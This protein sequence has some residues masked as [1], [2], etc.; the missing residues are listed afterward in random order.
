MVSTSKYIIMFALK[1]WES[2]TS[3][4]STQYVE[5]IC[6]WSTTSGKRF[7]RWIQIDCRN[8]FIEV[9]E[10]KNSEGT[11]PSPLDDVG[12]FCPR[13][14]SVQLYDEGIHEFG[15]WLFRRSVVNTGR[16]VELF[17]FLR[18]VG[19]FQLFAASCGASETQCTNIAECAHRNV[20]IFYVLIYLLSSCK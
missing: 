8:V 18:W 19:L 16:Y 15:A 6:V 3:T 2:K 14:S 20:V 17:F 5:L 12:S 7:R 9:C 13:P 4:C 1:L 10:S 11:T